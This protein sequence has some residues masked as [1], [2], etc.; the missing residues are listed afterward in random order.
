VWLHVLAVTLGRLVFLVLSAALLRVLWS[1]IGLQL[2]VGQIDPGTALLLVGFVAIWLC[3][4]L[5]G[6]ALH[7]WGSLTW[8]RVL[9]APARGGGRAGRHAPGDP[10]RS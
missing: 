8:T 10:H 3:L 1:P 6:G 4:L 5:G 7:A 9:A 2:D